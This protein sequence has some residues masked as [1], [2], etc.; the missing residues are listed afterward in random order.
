MNDVERRPDPDQ[1]LEKIREQ[2]HSSA[3]GKLKVF[4]GAAPGVGKTFT[5]LEA[6]R[7]LK[8]QGVDVVI[9]LIET[10]GRREIQAL[11][12]GFEIL[13]RKR[14]R[15]RDLDFEE[16]DLDAA[17]QRR[18]AVLLT[19]ELAHTNIPGSRH[20][21]RCQ[22]VQ[23]LLAAG[24]TVYTTLN[25]QHLESVNDIVE[26]ITGVKIRE[27][28]PDQILDQ[29]DEI[30]LVDISPGDLIQRLQEGK[31][32]PGQDPGLALGNF[33]KPG[34]LIALRELS[35]RQVADRVEADLHV[36]RRA[37]D[38]Q[39]VWRA[40]ERVLVCV[41]PSPLSARVARIASRIAKSLH[42]EWTAVSVE[43]SRIRRLP[44][45]DKARVRHHL[46]L[47]EDLGAETRVLFG[48]NV[49]E[50]IIAYARAHNISLIV[51]GKP[52]T[53]R[54]R[55]WLRGSLVDEV[56]RQ[57]GDIEIYV[58]QGGESEWP[59]AGA[60]PPRPSHSIPWKDYGWSCLITA[61]CAAFAFFLR[62]FLSESDV[63]VIFLAGIFLAA[64]SLTRRAAYLTALLSVAAFDYFFIPPH[65]TF[66]IHDTRYI[67]TF[68]AIV[69]VGLL[70]GNLVDRVK[71]QARSARAR[72]YRTFALYRLTEKLARENDTDHLVQTA[73]QQTQEIFKSDTTIFLED[74]KGGLAPAANAGAPL[75][76][77]KEIITAQWCFTH[78]KPAGNGTPT[79]PASEGLYLPLGPGERKLGVVGVRPRSPDVF[80]DS[81][82]YQLLDA[83]VTQ[84]SI[85]LE[86]TL[87][88]ESA[89]QAQVLM[90]TERLRNAL[91]SSISHD[92]RTPLGAILGAVTG[93]L[94]QRPPL[95]P[96]QMELL[97][98]IQEE[99]HRLARLLQNLLEMTRIEGGGFQLNTDWHL[100]EEVIGSALRQLSRTLQSR[101]VRVRVDSDLPLVRMDGLLIELVLINLIENADKYSPKPEAVE[102]TA[103]L[104]DQGVV[105]TVSDHGA[106]FEPGEEQRIFDKFYRGSK[107]HARGAGL[108]LA[109][110]KA[111]VEAHG[112][113]I[114]A[115]NRTDA[116]GAA[117][118]F[119]LP[120]DLESSG[121]QMRNASALN[122]REL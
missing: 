66:Y 33:F 8:R 26:Q 77:A 53:P 58:V 106:G 14:M 81:D 57:S 36:Y 5:M 34:N 115:V 121:I 118:A 35:L 86:R 112:G 111:I 1:L 100:P 71:E 107:A 82:Q 29:A 116:R 78:G 88:A 75:D 101:T 92:L 56:I 90:E 84:I 85:A 63:V 47:A 46:R 13:P 72:E 20:A 7:G 62:K 38:I 44:E 30:E 80:Q 48:E 49:S 113:R 51:I 3:K 108:G 32:Y 45:K 25:V 103:V 59:A 68:L 122:A 74:E 117:V 21:K 79:L 97:E 96:D 10:H 65:F 105:I 87:L 55:E 12:E 2:N 6:A 19:D 60:A 43:T 95:P 18:P 109:I 41:G 4:L 42:A 31:V 94:E 37:H 114:W 64:F 23:E 67:L 28:L 39:K 99:A 119:S 24:I 15:Y 110:C 104:Q 50:E 76:N 9:G 93:I 98:T 83:A 16:F 54:W 89:R 17:L 70:M 73:V 52:M 27:T 69:L 22:D 102:I 61:L 11:L 91:L 40:A 120:V